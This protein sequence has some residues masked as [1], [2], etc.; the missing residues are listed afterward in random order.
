VAQPNQPF[1]NFQIMREVSG[2]VRTSFLLPV[3]RSGDPNESI[4]SAAGIG[5]TQGQ[6]NEDVRAI[7]RDALGPLVEAAFEV[8]LALDEK[9]YGGT[10]KTIWSSKAGAY[11]ETYVPNVDINGYRK[12]QVRYGAMSGLD[13]VNQGVMVMQ[14]LGSNIISRTDAMEL[15]PFVEDPQRTK[16]RQLQEALETAMVSSLQ[17][18]ALQGL[19]PAANFA[20]LM[21]AVDSDEVT[22]PEAIVALIPPPPP[23]APGQAPGAPATA[24]GAEQPQAPGVAGA[25]APGNSQGA[26]VA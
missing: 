26:T 24:P 4:I 17:Q 10:T 25:A 1:S 14:Q 22:L 23:V 13:E 2:S 15:S 19:I 7:Q 21:Q 16:K 20:V 12:V 8:A 9:M 18:Q 11:K 5:A 6:F 3:S